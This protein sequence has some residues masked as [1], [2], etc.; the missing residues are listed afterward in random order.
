MNYD[1]VIGSSSIAVGVFS[2]YATTTAPTIVGG[3]AGELVSAFA[4]AFPLCLY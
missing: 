4:M 3:D 1:N 2:I